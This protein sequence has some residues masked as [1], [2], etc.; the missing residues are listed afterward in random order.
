LQVFKII[1]EKKINWIAEEYFS[2]FKTIALLKN[3]WN[4]DEKIQNCMMN[5]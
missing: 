4:T 5:S 3:Y 2:T 1:K